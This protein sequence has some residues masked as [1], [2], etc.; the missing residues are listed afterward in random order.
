MDPNMSALERAFFLARS[1]QYG[2]PDQIKRKLRH[3]GYSISQIYG[4]ALL[5]QLRAVIEA[6]RTQAMQATLPNDD[7]SEPAT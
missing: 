3:E 5:K 2:T 4:T 6:A 1:G 7:P